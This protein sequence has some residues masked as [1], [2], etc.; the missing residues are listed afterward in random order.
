[1]GVV[2][3]SILS[4][5]FVHRG[6]DC[7]ASLLSMI[8]VMHYV[9]KCHASVATVAKMLQRVATSSCEQLEKT[10]SYSNR[11]SL[12]PLIVCICIHMS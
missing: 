9:T 3:K 10:G 8:E 5:V 6:M 12:E 11:R 2:S 4:F 1:M 7:R